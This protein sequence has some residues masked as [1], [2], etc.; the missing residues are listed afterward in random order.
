MP[1]KIKTATKSPAITLIDII[2][3]KANDSGPPSWD[4]LNRALHTALDLAITGGFEFYLG[5]VAVIVD[6]YNSSHWIGADI[7]WIYTHAI[8]HENPSAHL[9][10]EA[11]RK[12]EPIIADE[13]T[14]H[15]SGSRVFTRK[16]ER[17]CVGAQ[18]P[19]K[20]LTVTVNSFG[21]FPS[22]T[23]YANA[24][25]HKTERYQV[26]GRGKWYDREVP[27]KRFKITAADVQAE[28]KLTKER[29]DLVDRLAFSSETDK[30]CRALKLSKRNTLDMI[31]IEKL[32]E[33]ADKFAPVRSA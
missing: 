13:V 2:W 9:S 16:R 27:D 17:L 32:R 22:G 28:R 26:G 11:Y 14:L 4:R 7:E 33:V 19:W 5:D 15:Q 29:S 24:T 18:L 30:I 21:K 3:H 1:A 23:D 20:G 10:F 8:A 25:S 12:R 31:P 6:N